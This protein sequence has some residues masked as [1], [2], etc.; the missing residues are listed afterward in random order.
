MWSPGVVI[1]SV[2]YYLYV[3]EIWWID[4]KIVSFGRLK[5]LWGVIGGDFR[6]EPSRTAWFNMDVRA[7]PKCRFQKSG[8]NDYNPKR[9]RSGF[10]R[11][12]P[13]ISS[14]IRPQISERQKNE[15]GPRILRT[16]F[17]S[18]GNLGGAKIW[19][20]KPLKFNAMILGRRPCPWGYFLSQAPRW[21]KKNWNV[22]SRKKGP[23]KLMKKGLRGR[24]CW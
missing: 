14:E 10:C 13:S 23:S 4:T 20:I 6:P 7:T 1:F 24:N 8:K 3:L 17:H 16:E 9:V 18:N 5:F 12:L 19:A 11:T 2:I 22:N 15:L 21:P